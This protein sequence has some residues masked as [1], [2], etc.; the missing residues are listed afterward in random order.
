MT[1]PEWL[2]LA[3]KAGRSGRR[4]IVPEH[5]QSLLFLSLRQRHFQFELAVEVILDHALVAAGDKDEV[6]DAGFAGFVDDVLDE[7]PV[8]HRQHFLRHGFGRR[9]EAGS[10]PGDGKHGFANKF[11]GLLFGITR[12]GECE[13]LCCLNRCASEQE[14]MD[15]EAMAR[16]SS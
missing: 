8:D 16:R 2:L 3:G 15:A 7:R 11:H 10:E 4:Q 5:I 6:L 13:T 1:E 12:V 9:Q 14:A